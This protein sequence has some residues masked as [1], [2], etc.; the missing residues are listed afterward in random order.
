M[1]SYYDILHVDKDSSPGDIKKSYRK[2]ALKYH[3]DK[4]P[5]DKQAEDKFKEVAEAYSIL[6]N[7]EERAK[8][9]SMSNT[10]S[11]YGRSNTYNGSEWGGMSME[12]I[13]EDLKGTGFEKNFDHMFGNG[14][15]SSVKG[16]DIESN[17]SITIEEAFYGTTKKI[18]LEG[19]SFR[20]NISA[21]IHTGQLLRIKG[22]GHEHYINS[23]APNGDL[24]IKINVKDNPIF[25]R[26]GDNIITFV[27]VDHLI[28]ILGGKVK[29]TTMDGEIMI[30]IKKLTSNESILRVKGKGMPYYKSSKRGDLLVKIKVTFPESITEDEEELYKKILENRNNI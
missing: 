5:E 24:L 12:D 27:E 10:F 15:G 19:K 29:V 26:E 25:K 1:A 16:N 21:G 14:Y 13:L 17:L 18:D 11:G 28:A 3:P 7:E 4:N 8:Y 6:G 9:D 30:N 2:L 20:L 23:Q 22:K